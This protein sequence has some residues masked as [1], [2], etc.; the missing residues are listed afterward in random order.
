MNYYNSELTFDNNDSVID[1]LIHSILLESKLD[2]NTCKLLV[3]LAA[4][5]LK[6]IKGLDEAQNTCACRMLRSK[7]LKDTT[8]VVWFGDD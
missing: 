7:G 6:P 3:P 1:C 2:E 5:L 8:C 4:R